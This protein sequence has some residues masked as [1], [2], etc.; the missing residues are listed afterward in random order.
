MIYRLFTF[1][2]YCVK[3]LNSYFK[4][5][6]VLKPQKWGRCMNSKLKTPSVEQLFEAVLSLENKDECFDFF[7]DVCTINELLSLAQRFEVAKML[8]EHKTYL[9]ISSSANL[10][11][12]EDGAVRSY[13]LNEN[14]I[15]KIG[16]KNPESE[17][18][19]ELES[20]IVSR[21][22][23]Q[24]QSVDGEWYYIDNGSLNGT[25]YNGSKIKGAS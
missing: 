1:K 5:A 14:Q 19:I 7:E 11:V 3:I 21:K 23:G 4:K 13:P 6:F 18:D 16:R 17:N 20:K 10:V 22:H 9:S 15:W 12:L 2:F 24:I 25:Y 8:R